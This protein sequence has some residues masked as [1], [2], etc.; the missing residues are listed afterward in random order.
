MNA[1]EQFLQCVAEGKRTD[2]T[3]LRGATLRGESLCGAQMSM[4]HFERSDL[5]G[6]DWSNAVL[7]LCAFDAAQ[8]Q[9]ACFDNA[10]VEDSNFSAADLTGASF[11][12]GAL[13]ETVF[14]RALLQGAVFDDASGEGLSFRGA[15][16]RGASLVGARFVDADFRGADLRGANLAN[17]ELNRADFRGALLE[18]TRFDGCN[19]FGADFDAGAGP[20]ATA[21]SAEPVAA[22]DRFPSVLNR[23]LQQNGVALPALIEQLFGREGIAGAMAAER[24]NEEFAELLT[25]VE[26]LLRE[27]ESLGAGGNNT[28]AVRAELEQ[29]SEH[30]LA[31][32]RRVVPPEEW[33]QLLAAFGIDLAKFQAQLSK[34]K[35]PLHD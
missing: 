27:L 11:R 2:E 15:D 31:E 13:S 34:D 6:T 23:H 26:P 30:A 8:A 22:D 35:P 20:H 10:C 16:L 24:N 7:R 28:A 4:S 1:I 9:G 29:L 5:T 14:E 21:A 33:E 25:A 12:N 17:A 18:G 19:C 3:D 32:L